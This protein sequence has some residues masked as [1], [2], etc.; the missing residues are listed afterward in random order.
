MR[1]ERNKFYELTNKYEGLNS[2][3]I[4]VCMRERAKMIH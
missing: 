4:E 2:K 1:R 3:N